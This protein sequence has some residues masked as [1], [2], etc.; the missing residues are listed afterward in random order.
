MPPHVTIEFLLA[1]AGKDAAHLAGRDL[2]YGPELRRNP[3]QLRRLFQRESR[4]LILEDCIKDKPAG[5]DWFERLNGPWKGAFRR[6]RLLV[7]PL[8]S[9]AATV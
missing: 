2:L 3:M 6:W 1:R 8:F 4:D 5:L 9:R 7:G